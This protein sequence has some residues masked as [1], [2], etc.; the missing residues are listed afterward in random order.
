LL[1]DRDKIDRRADSWL[2]R[3]AS[4]FKQETAKTFATQ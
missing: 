4:I 2:Q 1:E 3:A